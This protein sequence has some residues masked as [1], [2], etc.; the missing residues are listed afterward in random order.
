MP[1]SK[2]V[3]DK[4]NWNTVINLTEQNSIFNKVF[5]ENITLRPLQIRT[6]SFKRLKFDDKC[7]EVNDLKYNNLETVYN[8]STTKDPPVREPITLKI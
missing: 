5:S 3:N 1:Y 6:F 2:F 4:W 7:H 8:L